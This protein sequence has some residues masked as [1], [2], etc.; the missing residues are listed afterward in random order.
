MPSFE[1]AKKL[2]CWYRG[3]ALQVS[4]D[5]WMKQSRVRAN[6]LHAALGF[7]WSFCCRPRICLCAPHGCSPVMTYLLLGL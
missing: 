5:S 3:A 1:D 4:A 6:L 7:R 2:K